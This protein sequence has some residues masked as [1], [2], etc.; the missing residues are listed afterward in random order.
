MDSI[1][2]SMFSEP[3]A[4]PIQSTESSTPGGSLFGALVAAAAKGE[5]F[6]AEVSPVTPEDED[7][8]QSDS[9]AEMP[10]PFLVREWLAQ[11]GTPPSLPKGLIAGLEK[12]QEN[13]DPAAPE[14]TVADSPEVNEDETTET[15]G[16]PV[17]KSDGRPALAANDTP[18]ADYEHPLL[19]ADRIE[20][21][22][23]TSDSGKPSSMES[24]EVQP[25]AEPAPPTGPVN[26]LQYL[27]GIGSTA[28]QSEPGSETGETPDSATVRTLSQNAPLELQTPA[29]AARTGRT[30]TSTAP[31]EPST[32]PLSDAK[33]LVGH[34][35]DETT[36][37]SSEAPKAP[38]ASEGLKVGHTGTQSPSA[39]T[40]DPVPQYSSN[41]LPNTPSSSSEAVVA[42]PQ[43]ANASAATESSADMPVR[44]APSARN[45]QSSELQSLALHI[46]ARSA[47]GD[48]RFTIRLDPPELGRI[49]V[50]LSMNS[51]GHAQAVLA[52]EKPQTLDLLMRDASGLERALKDAGLELGT[53]LSFSL[54]EEGRP[55]F[56]RDD[57]Q[58][59]PI[60]TVDVVPSDKANALAAL[61]APLLE[62]LYGSRTARLDITV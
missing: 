1:A 19:A 25:I 46:A 29:P 12:F 62:H 13:A 28:P 20:S 35:V 59:A 56:T 37:Q 49:D 26:P 16:I 42:P 38:S 21:H 14:R 48:S 6:E 9:T 4:P 55:A 52:V 3:A 7:M 44:L 10:P 34:L 27:T 40:A 5:D 57:N 24:G 43:T 50:N 2:L 45:E 15:G 33:S 23:Q 54:K 11:T 31:V 60:R 8:A 61:N 32:A 58:G 41:A 53:N 51:Q 30:S 22:V 47:R 39:G 17:L 36:T 18:A